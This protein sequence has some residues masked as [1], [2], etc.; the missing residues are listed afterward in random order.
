VKTAEIRARLADIDRNALPTVAEARELARDAADAAGSIEPQAAP[1]VPQGAPDGQLTPDIARD[2]AEPPGELP[3]LASGA[4]VVFSP[5]SSAAPADLPTLEPATTPDTSE[6][7]TG[8]RRF[9]DRVRGLASKAAELL[10][11]ESSGGENGHGVVQRVLSMG[12]KVVGGWHHHN[13]QELN[14]GLAE[15]ADIAA[16]ELA[17]KAANTPTGSPKTWVERVLAE[18]LHKAREILH[19][20]RGSGP[21]LG[22]SNPQSDF[23]RL[24]EEWAAGVD[25]DSGSGPESP[26][27]GAHYDNDTPQPDGPDAD[28]WDITP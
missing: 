8:W 26:G 25:A 12:R 27:S 5:L 16:D 24:A 3:P 4:E 22:I 7:H 1:A 21:G 18:G 10:H 13:A 20:E 9:A 17:K 15:G 11:D 19:N 23:E 14:E 6:E 28:D 2:L